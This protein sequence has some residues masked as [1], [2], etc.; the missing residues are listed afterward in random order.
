MHDLSNW[1]DLKA[2]SFSSLPFVLD[3]MRSGL[4]RLKL[5]KR[6]G[7]FAWNS[8]QADPANFVTQYKVGGCSDT[9][10]E[11]QDPH[12]MVYCGTSVNRVA[13]VSTPSELTSWRDDGV[14]SCWID[15]PLQ[16]SIKQSYSVRRR[17]KRGF[18]SF[19]V[20]VNIHCPEYCRHKC[21]YH[22]KTYLHACGDPVLKCSLRH[23]AWL[24]HFLFAHMQI[25]P[26][27]TCIG[28]NMTE[29]QLAF[30]RFDSWAKNSFPVT[31]SP[32][33]AIDLL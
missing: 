10:S 19:L 3:V 9:F 30:H 1:C 15:I 21:K 28:S 13:F 20:S 23:T 11:I 6:T 14:E 7:L 4:L 22:E 33:E 32:E 27:N 29:N 18:Q 8:E 12:P 2:G 31:K 17:Y 5:I 24:N 16:L 25:V 26:R